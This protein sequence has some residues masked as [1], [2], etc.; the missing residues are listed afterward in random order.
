MTTHITVHLLP[1]E[2]DWF[3]WQCR[4]LKFASAYLSSE[5]KIIFQAVLNLNLTDWNSS[6][7]PKEFFETKFSMLEELSSWADVR[8]TADSENQYMGCNDIRREAARNTTA[9]NIVY[10]DTDLVFTPTTLTALLQAAKT[11]QEKYY[12]VSPQTVKLWDYT[13]D[14]LVNPEYIYHPYGYEREVDPF[15]S[16]DVKSDS[17]GLIPLDT[18]KFGGGWFNLLSTDLLRKVDVPDSFGP[19]GPDDTFVMECCNIMKSKGIEV[20]QYV[21]DNCIVVENYKFRK[22]PYTSFL[23]SENRQKEYRQAAESN[24][25]QELKNFDSSLK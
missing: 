21:V 5:D 14:P 13:W 1:H 16:A 6:K 19:Y 15:L 2:I 20:Q 12:I 7:I 8:F 9:D 10:L 17:L 24:F 22:N 3:E 23:V 11:V 25:I 4:Q 18:F